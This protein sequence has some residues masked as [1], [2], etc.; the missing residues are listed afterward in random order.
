VAGPV[1]PDEVTDVT[2]IYDE[3][4]VLSS[5]I[6]S[7]AC[8]RMLLIHGGRTLIW[9]ANMLETPDRLRAWALMLERKRGHNRA[10]VLRAVHTRQEASRSNSGSWRHYAPVPKG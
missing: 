8:L 4:L 9:H 10:G 1:N 3:P 5:R 7:D 2:A 6:S